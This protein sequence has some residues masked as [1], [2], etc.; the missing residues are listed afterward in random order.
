[1]KYKILILTI[2]LSFNFLYANNFKPVWYRAL[3]YKGGDKK[4]IRDFSK[5]NINLKQ[6]KGKV[7]YGTNSF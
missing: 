1:M 6:S 7:I 5:E 3:S 4:S 2:V